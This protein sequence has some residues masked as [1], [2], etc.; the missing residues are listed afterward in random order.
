MLRILIIFTLI[1]SIYLTQSFAQQQTRKKIPPEKPKLIIGIIVD[2]MR[3]DYIS[4]YWDKFDTKGFKRLIGEGAFCKNAN[5]DY[6]FTQTAVGHATISTGALPAVHGIVSNTWYNRLKEQRIYCVGDDKAKTTGSESE[7]AGKKSPK[8]LITTT[9]GDEL[10]LA[11][12]GKSKVIAISLKDRAAILSAGHAA[13]AAYWFDEQTGNFVTSSYYLD[14]LPKWVRKFNKEKNPDLYL[15]RV[16]STL[17]PIEEYT[18]SIADNNPFETGIKGQITFPY[19]LAEI[20]EEKKYDLLK[21]VPFGNSLTKDFT[22]NAIVNEELGVDDFT[23]L[24]IV[25]LS[26]TDYIGHSY[27]PT[28]VENEDTYLRLDEEIAHFLSFIDNQIGKENCLVYLT[29]DHGVAHSPKYLESQHIP[30]GFF[31]DNYAITLLKTYLNAIYGYGEWVSEYID[32]QIYLNRNLIEDSKL[33]LDEFQKRTAQ[34]FIQFTGVANAMTA[35]NLENSDYSNGIFSKMKNN[36]NQNRS[37]DILIN[38]E[39]NWMEDSFSATNHNSPYAYD[40]HVPLIWY[41]WKVN[42]KTITRR[43][44]MTEIAPTIA[45]FLNMPFPNGCLSEPI[46]E[47]TE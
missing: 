9:T 32:Q 41:G 21:T 6:I 25:S 18:E 2:Q 37:G 22:I 42:R 30:A 20:R 46:I 31:N 36:Y 28:S 12:N 11:S 47:I 44:S 26:A 7:D 10:K 4:R 19:N 14:S 34:F 17:R 45:T 5:F 3:Y 38:L 27:G 33:S 39:P 24:L 1:F 40:T 35:T 8:N 43:V 13:D 29:A 16:W 23:D 15:N